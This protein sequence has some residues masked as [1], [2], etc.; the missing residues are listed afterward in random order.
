MQEHL[1][2]LEKNS[3]KKLDKISPQEIAETKNLITDLVNEIAAL[4]SVEEKKEFL[5]FQFG[6]LKNNILHLAA[7]FGDEGST[8]KILQISGADKNYIDSKNTGFF[9]PLHFAACSGSVA[10][11]QLLLSAGAEKN[12][13]A[14]AENRKWVPLHY[15]A[16]FGHAQVVEALISAGVDK[17]TKTGF[18]LTPLIVAAEFGQKN[19]VEFLL[20][21][22]ADK[23]ARTVEDNHSMNALHYAAVGNFIDVVLLFLDDGV[24][25]EAE[26]NLGFSALE[27]AAKSGHAKVVF[28]LLSWGASKAEAIQKNFKEIKSEEVKKEI[29]AYV[30]AKKNLFNAKWLKTFAPTLIESL[31]KFDKNNLGEAK[32]IISPEV[33]YNAH[34]ILALKSEFGLVKKTTKNLDQ[35]AAENKISEL[36]SAL[37][38]LRKIE[39]EAKMEK[40]RIRSN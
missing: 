13:Q 28:L 35:F 33:S 10:V 32:V 25:I 5:N 20:K 9:T 26:T 40:M 6:S 2:I 30:A 18:G 12:P 22:R 7:K 14:S 29:S 34:A 37:E 39:L 15:A 36:V 16:Q 19:V 24:D 11:A 3:D 17:E 23:N 27:I 31:A 1:D 4:D 38:N 21:I 8:A